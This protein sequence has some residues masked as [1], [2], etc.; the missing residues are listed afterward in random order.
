MIARNHPESAQPLSAEA[1]SWIEKDTEVLRIL[2]LKH[3]TSNKSQISISNNR[4][5]LGI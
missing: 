2:N 4:D 1:A 3:Q 5:M